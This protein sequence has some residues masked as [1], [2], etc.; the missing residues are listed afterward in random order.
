MNKELVVWLKQSPS[1]Q[2][3]TTIPSTRGDCE[4]LSGCCGMLSDRQ[5]PC[6]WPALLAGIIQSGVQ[7][8]DLVK[9]VSEPLKMLINH[10]RLELGFSNKGEDV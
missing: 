6:K 1:S 3:T 5:H 2:F 10:H 7:C 9:N 8:G 4:A